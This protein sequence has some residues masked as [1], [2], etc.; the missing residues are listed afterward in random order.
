MKLT[1]RADRSSG[2]L[3]EAPDGDRR[4]PGER[5]DDRETEGDESHRWDEG[6]GLQPTVHARVIGRGDRPRAGPG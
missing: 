2:T 1:A 6:R 4:E 5:G 3:S